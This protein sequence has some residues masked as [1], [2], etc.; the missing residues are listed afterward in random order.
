MERKKTT[1]ASL[2]KQIKPRHSLVTLD[3]I[4]KLKYFGHT[5]PTLD[6][7]EKDLAFELTEEEHSGQYG[8]TKDEE[9]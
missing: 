9:P 2:I 3:V 4:D 1:N 7:L 8:Q 5:M 6:L